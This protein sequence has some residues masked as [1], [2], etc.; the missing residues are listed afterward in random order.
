MVVVVVKRNLLLQGVV[1]VVAVVVGEMVWRWGEHERKGHWGQ[2]LRTDSREE[3]LLVVVV[4]R[5]EEKRGEM[6]WKMEQMWR[7]NQLPQLEEGG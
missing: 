1:V 4:Q 5:K 2:G 7:R 6:K 3:H